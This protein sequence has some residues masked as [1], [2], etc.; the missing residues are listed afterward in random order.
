MAAIQ[1][2]TTV[3]PGGIIQIHSDE[4]PEGAQ[5]QVIVLVEKPPISEPSRPRESGFR[6]DQINTSPDFDE[7]SAF[8][9]QHG[10]RPKHMQS[11]CVIDVQNPLT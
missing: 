5:A 11:D 1:Q 9:R 8:E 6:K 7:P 10:Q 4:L 3:Q 2:N